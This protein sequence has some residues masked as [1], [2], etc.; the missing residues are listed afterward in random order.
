MSVHANCTEGAVDT[1]LKEDGLR[2]CFL[3]QLHGH[4]DN[5]AAIAPGWEN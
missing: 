4:C 3:L 5:I 2:R 1:S